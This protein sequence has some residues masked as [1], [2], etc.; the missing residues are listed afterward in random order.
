LRDQ[1][2]E[3]RGRGEPGDVVRCRLGPAADYGELLALAPGDRLGR[4]ADV[5]DRYGTNGKTLHELHLEVEWAAGSRDSSTGEQT[6]SLWTNAGR[7]E[8]FP[9]HSY[10]TGRVSRLAAGYSPPVS[11]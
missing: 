5:L 2:G 4:Y 8:L 6:P 7:A 1:V 11:A 10:L 9:S 3:H